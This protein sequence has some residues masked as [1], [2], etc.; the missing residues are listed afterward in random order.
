MQYE[1]KSQLLP[2]SRIIVAYKWRR[3]ISIEAPN[4]Y[5]SLYKRIPSV[6]GG[7]RPVLMEHFFHDLGFDS[8][9]REFISFPVPSEIVFGI[10]K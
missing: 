9:K 2:N 7:C 3:S 8:V 4:F 10:K 1:L 6:M 5:E